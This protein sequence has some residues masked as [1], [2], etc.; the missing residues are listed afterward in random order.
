MAVNQP[1]EA[2]LD[3]QLLVVTSDLGKER[4]CQ[5]FSEGLSFDPS[6]FAQHSVSH[7]EGL[8]LNGQRLSL[9]YGSPFKHT[10]THTPSEFQIWTIRHLICVTQGS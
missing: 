1:R 4:A 6:V 10:H 5:L 2:A 7:S 8:V 3:A 9:R